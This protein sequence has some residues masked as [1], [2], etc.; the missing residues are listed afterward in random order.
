M[1]LSRKFIKAGDAVCTFDHH[2][3][4]PYFRREFLMDFLS[5][6]AEITIC[7]LGFY[8]LY[9]NGV[10][11][12]KGP[13]APYIANT[14]DLCY[15]DRYDIAAYLTKGKNVIGIL[16][17]N[18]FRNPFGGFVWRFDR[19]PHIGPLCTALCLECYGEGKYFRMEA[20]E[21]FKTHPS[22]ILFDDIRMGC[23]Y[24]ARLE[25]DGW[26]LP[27]F[28][29]AGWTPAIPCD[30]PKGE[31]RLCGSAPVSVRREIAAVSVT[32]YD[33]LAFARETTAAGS[34]DAADTVRENIHVFD[35]GVNTAGVTR[36]RLNGRPGQ[37]ITIRHGEYLV[38]GKFDLR[39]TI[40]SSA[41]RQP[42]YYEY[43]QCDVYICRGGE[44]EF[45]PRFKYDGFR[46]AYVEGLLPEQLRADTLTCMEMTSI[47][48]QRA[49][50]V[51]SCHTLTALQQMTEQSDRSNFVYFPTDCP[52]REKNGWTG[53]ASLS[54]EQLLL[55]FDCAKSLKEWLRNV[56]K[57]Q[58]SEGALPGIVPTG[59]WGFEWGNGPVWDAVIVNLPYY[60]YRY[61]GDLSA[62]AENADAIYRYLQYAARRRDEK[63]LV[64][65]GLGDWVDPFERER[66][67]IAAP[68]VVTDSITIYDIAEKAAKLFS[69]AK[70]PT[71]AAW[72]QTF[73]AEMRA[74]IRKHLVDDT[75]L[76]FGDCQTCQ[77]IAL[78]TGIFDPEET[79]AARRHLLRIIHRDGDINACGVL[80]NRYLFHVLAE[81]GEIDLAYKIITGTGRTCYGYW[82]KRGFTTLCESFLDVDG[83]GL[84]SRNHHFFGD[85]SSFMIRKIAGIRPNP[86][87]ADRDAFAIVPHIPKDLESATGSFQRAD[88]ALECGFKRENDNISFH[89][90]VPGGMHGTFDYGSFHKELT[91]G[92]YCFTLSAKTGAA[93]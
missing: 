58:N 23:R 72:T 51:S 22:P 6:R 60:I 44:E 70:M 64:A 69:V 86:D 56:R 29:D 90:S 36:L 2:V 9:I 1:H 19:A 81:A 10:N 87:L 21:H 63:G 53:D 93:V 61:E 76:V 41:D 85:I 16:L 17:G 31:P 20:D 5:Q 43:A 48:E 54:A 12:T 15:Y 75:L 46:Y 62:F 78:G 7:G 28:D 89:I 18:G 71:E 25:S 84:D 92:D 26:N 88:G 50:F 32:H 34:K 14:D 38:N 47:G 27:G 67:G 49:S 74:A 79:E 3:N 42:R 65:Y 45:L 66:G 52:H 13:L 82:V 57:A 73:A 33:R 4:A 55:N 11:V 83:P 40:F 68:L 35:F 39:T 24:D 30:A 59:G 37:K 80:G 77:A 91:G 8:E